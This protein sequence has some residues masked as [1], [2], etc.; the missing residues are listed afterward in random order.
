MITATLWFLLVTGTSA[1]SSPTVVARFMAVADCAKA[2]MQIEHESGARSDM[3]VLKA[4]CVPI[5]NN[6]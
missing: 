2:A 4:I 6:E 1:Q 3:H 5:T